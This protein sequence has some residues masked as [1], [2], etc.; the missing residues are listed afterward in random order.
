MENFT[1]CPGSRTIHTN[2]PS[3]KARGTISS[4]KWEWKLSSGGFLFR[5]QKGHSN[6]TVPDSISHSLQCPHSKPVVLPLFHIKPSTLGGPTQSFL[7]TLPPSC[8]HFP[9]KQHLPPV[10]RGQGTTVAVLAAI[11]ALPGSEFRPHPR[12]G[13]IPVCC[14][15]LNPHSTIIIPLQMNRLID[16]RSYRLGH[17]T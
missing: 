3:H 10:R 11:E 15:S 8:G 16:N 2:P 5:R 6:A 1:S 14:T 4:P 7:R 9:I 13:R 17:Q 12:S